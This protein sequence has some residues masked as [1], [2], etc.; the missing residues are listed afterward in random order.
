MSAETFSYN[1]FSGMT[2]TATQAYTNHQRFVD[3]A[4]VRA[5]YWEKKPRRAVCWLVR[6]GKDTAK[7]TYEGVLM[8]DEVY[9]KIPKEFAYILI[10]HRDENNKLYECILEEIEI[11]DDLSQLD[12][13]TYK[14]IN[15]T[16]RKLIAWHEVTEV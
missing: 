12:D 15:F 6:D 2:M 14:Q 3:L 1:G 8:F 7:F 16:A 5:I 4:K 9:E 11:K 13:L 10:Q